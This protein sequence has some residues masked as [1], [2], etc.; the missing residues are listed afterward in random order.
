M[1]KYYYLLLVYF[2]I[3]PTAIANSPPNETRVIQNFINR[4][5][6][7]VGNFQNNLEPIVFKLFIIL[8]TI[9]LVWIGA[10]LIIKNAGLSDFVM[11]I[12]SFIMIT[13]FW[14]WIIKNSNTLINVFIQSMAESANI[15]TKSRVDFSP[16]EIMN[17]GVEIS[18]LIIDQ[19]GTFDLVIYG[20]LGLILVIIYFYLAGLLFV[21]LIE[22][23][24]VS[25]AGIILLAFAGSPFTSDLSKKYLMYVVSVSIKIYFIYLIVGIGTQVIDVYMN[26]Y[27][28]SSQQL[29]ITSILALIGCLFLISLLADRVPTMAQGIISGTSVG[30]GMQTSVGGTIENIAKAG[31]IGAMTIAGAGATAY[32]AG[33]SAFSGAIDGAKGNPILS[34]ASAVSPS[35]SSLSSIDNQAGVSSSNSSSSPKSQKGSSLMQS[36]GQAIKTNHDDGKL[37]S[38]AKTATRALVGAGMGFGQAITTGV[39]SSMQ[40]TFSES[41]YFSTA[42]AIEAQRMSQKINQQIDF[43][44]E[45]S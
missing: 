27:K 22:I 25:G 13:G 14:V 28:N 42:R 5:K 7:D 9:S 33:K 1:K 3:I 32:Q 24:I 11:E 20:L 44:K 29:E 30:G 38:G 40:K 12:T 31:A 19:A 16:V 23:Y 2:F 6:N 37:V 18:V 35:I 17:K 41:P 43:G 10:R 21:A 26:I 34:A 36:F 45:S 4:F 39:K 8:S 15:A